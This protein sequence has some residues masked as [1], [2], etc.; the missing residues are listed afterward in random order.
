MILSLF[1]KTKLSEP[2]YAVY[3][4][5]VAQSRREV[6]YAQWD[7]PDTLTGRFDMISL[8]AALVF[9]RLRSSEKQSKDF[10]QNVFDCFFHDMDRSL[11]EM[12]V[13]DLS[14]GKR[15]E[16]M[17]S[18]FYGMLSNLSSILDAGDRARLIDFVSRNFHAGATHPLAERFA[19]YI[20]ESDETLASQS[21]EQI[22][23]G[24][25]TFGDPK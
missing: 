20:L 18:L 6:F 7:V 21:V 1:R 25:V 3:N 11:R 19:D 4:A 17:G 22:M 12:G 13:G 9:R 5:I 15:I 23:A 24:S 10:S 14:V 16:K 2:V 8:H